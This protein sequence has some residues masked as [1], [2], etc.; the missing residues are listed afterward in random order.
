MAA[1]SRIKGDRALIK[2]LTALERRLAPRAM[3][4]SLNRT[5]TK[6]R[7]Q[8][9]RDARAA[10]SKLSGKRLRQMVGITQ[11]ARAP[12]KLTTAVSREYF[13]RAARATGPVS[14][15]FTA[16]MKTGHTERFVRARIRPAKYSGSGYTRGRPR[17]SPPNLPILP[18][19]SRGRDLRRV[20]SQALQSAAR[21]Q[22][23]EFLPGEFRRQLARQV[24]KIH[25]KGRA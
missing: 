12:Q 1:T 6:T 18:L 2:A 22:M 19:E 7:Q 25:A 13:Q 10:G 16:T 23:R 14:A 8:V 5:G 21:K 20:L 9:V 4:N 3:A 11:R 24:A 15:P 17:T